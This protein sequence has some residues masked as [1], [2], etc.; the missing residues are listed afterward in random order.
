MAKSGTGLVRL[1]TLSR[2]GVAVVEHPQEPAAVLCSGTW[3][4]L[5]GS[6]EEREG[7]TAFLFSFFL[8]LFLNGISQISRDLVA[9]R[10][11]YHVR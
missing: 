10:Q 8:L 2:G 6:G 11:R 7:G 4:Y 1:G 3:C 5:Y 9:A